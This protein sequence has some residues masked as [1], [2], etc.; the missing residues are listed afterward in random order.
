[1]LLECLFLIFDVL[2]V[3]SPPRA[4]RVD[5]SERALDCRGRYYYEF[6]LKAL[7]SLSRS[8][9]AILA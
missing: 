6:E 8:L 3:L 2:A 9:G 7:P 1:M 4:D 5:L